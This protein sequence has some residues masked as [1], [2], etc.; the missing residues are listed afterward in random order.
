MKTE[1][2]KAIKGQILSVKEGNI[3]H[4]F[5]V[6]ME[7]PDN[8]FFVDPDDSFLIVEIL[9]KN[10]S[11]YRALAIKDDGKMALLTFPSLSEFT[12]S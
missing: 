12:I 5:A 2:L 3:S 8:W 4:Y 1:S 10:N 11:W 7:D 6:P 9:K